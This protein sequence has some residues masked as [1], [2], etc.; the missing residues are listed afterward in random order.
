M[1]AFSADS[2]L[3]V[4]RPRIYM[5]GNDVHVEGNGGP[6]DALVISY[7]QLVTVLYYMRQEQLAVE[8]Q[9]LPPPPK[10]S[11]LRTFFEQLFWIED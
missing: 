10:K 2:N 4:N 3:I 5:R 11:K 1:L 7:D 6:D 9:K 8:R